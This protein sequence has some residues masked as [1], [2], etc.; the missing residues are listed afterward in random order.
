MISLAGFQIWNIQVICSETGFSEKEVE[1]IA[2]SL[3][4]TGRLQRNGFRCYT[5]DRWSN[6]RDRNPSIEKAYQDEMAENS[7]ITPLHPPNTETVSVSVSVSDRAD[8]VPTRCKHGADTVPENPEYEDFVLKLFPHLKEKRAALRKEI[9]ALDGLIRLEYRHIGKAFTKEAWGKE[10]FAV[11]SWMRT[12]N[13]QR[14]TFPGWSAVFGSISR[15]RE[16]ACQKFLNAQKAYHTAVEFPEVPNHD[17]PTDSPD[18][19]ELRLR[20]LSEVS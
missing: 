11:L 18:S 9:A 10:V 15:L 19:R 17:E 1:R 8:T 7:W 16:N 3:E 12:D 2:R 20:G 4:A 6:D 5:P 14:G 13:I